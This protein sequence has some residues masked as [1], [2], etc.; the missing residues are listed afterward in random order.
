M[1]DTWRPELESETFVLIVN[2]QPSRTFDSMGEAVIAARRLEKVSSTIER[3]V[4][5]VEI[6]RIY[7]PI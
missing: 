6:T 1:T 3:R 4:E 5:K 2:G 7:E